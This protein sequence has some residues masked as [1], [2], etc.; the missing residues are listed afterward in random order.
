MT[1]SITPNSNEQNQEEPPLDLELLDEMAEIAPE[2]LRSLIDMYLTQADE[3]IVALR[4]AIAEGNSAD[5][6]HL[7]HKLAGSSAA[8][9]VTTM[10]RLLRVLEQRGRQRH[11]TDAEAILKMIVEQLDVSRRLLAEYVTAKTHGQTSQ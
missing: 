11:L 1:E 10:M 3:T 5:V 6:D 7:A 4:V 2:D 8:C 9:G